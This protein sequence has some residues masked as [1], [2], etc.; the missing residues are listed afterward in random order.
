LQSRTLPAR[1][2]ISRHFA[3]RRGESIAPPLQ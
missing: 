2:E 3:P 1:R